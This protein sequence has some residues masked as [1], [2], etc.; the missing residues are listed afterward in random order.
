MGMSVYSWQQQAYGKQNISFVT[1]NAANHVGNYLQALQN[2][3]NWFNSIIAQ[4]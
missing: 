1:T 2:D 3:L 4:N